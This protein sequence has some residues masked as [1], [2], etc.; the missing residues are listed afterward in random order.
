[1]DVKKVQSDM[2]LTRKM[3][4]L[5]HKLAA[6]MFNSLCSCEFHNMTPH[7]KEIWKTVIELQRL[8]GSHE[9]A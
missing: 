8:G 7:E 2:E 1:M 3:L 6:L 4:E 5:G 9:G